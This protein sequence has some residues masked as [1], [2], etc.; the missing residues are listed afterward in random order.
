MKIIII[1]VGKKHQESIKDAIFEFE[2]RISN[3]FSVE[4]KIIPSDTV[5]KE[6][7]KIVG[8]C[9]E[10]DFVFALDEGGEEL[11]TI[12]FSQKLQKNIS[13]GVKGLVFVIGGSY[14][15]SQEVLSRANFIL[16]LSKLTFPHQIVR[17][18]LVEQ[19]Y[20]ALSILNGSKYHH[21]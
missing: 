9:K 5:D 12:D 4:W 19:I 20:R 7:K 2:K 13:S 18:I 3:Q 1:S 6:G 8:L 14:G 11:T 15:L 16:S 21:E 17:L 10:G